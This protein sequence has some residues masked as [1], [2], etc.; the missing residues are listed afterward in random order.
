MNLHSATEDFFLRN[1]LESLS[2]NFSVI[3]LRFPGGPVRGVIV[4]VKNENGANDYDFLS[5]YFAPWLG[6]PEDPVT[7]ETVNLIPYGHCI[8]S[9][10]VISTS[11]SAHCLLA[12]YWSG[13]L[14]KDKLFG[15]DWQLHCFSLII[16]Q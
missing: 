13:R 3:T 14:G 10:L 5:R 9:Q 15:S 16:Y 1:E 4:T 6:I 12:P 2:P 7:G 11:G 8:D